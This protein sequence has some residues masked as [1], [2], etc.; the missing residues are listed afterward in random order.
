MVVPVE[1]RMIHQDGEAAADEHEKEEQI[2]KVAPADPEGKAMRPAR[3]A[4]GRS[5]GRFK[6]RQ[7]EDRMLQPRK[8]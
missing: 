5:R 8:Q 1:S 3:S 4:F 7:S 2:R 6:V